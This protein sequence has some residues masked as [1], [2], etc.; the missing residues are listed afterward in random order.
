MALS[1]LSISCAVSAQTDDLKR[2]D[3]IIVTGLV[4]HKQADELVGN[5]TAMTRGEIVDNLTASLGETLSGQPGIASTAFGQGASRPILRGLGSD[6]VL[7]LTNGL[8]VIDAS[9]AS[10]DHQ[11]AVDGIDAQKIEILRGPA[12][13][14]YG[15][16]A[17]GGVVNVIDG[18]VAEEM[19]EDDFAADLYAALN[20]GSDGLEAAGRSQFTLGGNFAVT[21]SASIRELH[22]YDINGFSESAATRTPG[23]QE[24]EELFNTYVNTQTLSGGLS[25]IGDRAYLGL[26]LREQTSD[27]GLPAEDPFIDLEQ[28]RTDLKGGIE[29]SGMVFTGLTG[30]ISF[31]DYQHGETLPNGDVETVFK[32]KGNEARF[33]AAYGET[34][35]GGVIGLQRLDKEFEAI[36][37]E[38]FVTPTDTQS[39]GLFAFHHIELQNGVHLEGGLRYDDV[40]ILNRAGLGKRSFN[41]ISASF[42]LSKNLNENWFFGG[43][44][45]Y[46]TRAPS[47]VELFADGPHLATSQYEVGDIT[48]DEEHGLNVELTARYKSD[49]FSIGANVFNTQFSDFIFLEPGTTL[50]GGVPVT[51]KDGLD[52]FVFVQDEADFWGGEIYGEWFIGEGMKADWVLDG[53]FDFVKAERSNGD[54][55][56][57]MPPVTFNMGAKA[58]WDYV[59]LKGELTHAFEQDEQASFELPTDGYTSLDV[60]A[61]LDLAAL[62]LGQAGTKAFIEVHNLTDEEIR[63]STSVLKEEVPAPGRNVRMGVR[64]S[65]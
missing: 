52:V 3:L 43:A 15:G 20:T 35:N 31:V 21:L 54:N 34:D 36:G 65:F 32:N 11:V 24:V 12:A 56:P 40:E 28:T 60:K 13:L 39:L 55:L 17:I 49:S 23:A 5:V 25:W 51:V 45:S 46:T 2:E 8:G 41:P 7:V 4:D 42:S 1:A 63:H 10:P 27:Y 58:S 16:N 6:R 37:D 29:L 53:S 48:L 26:A 22:D 57:L 33:E 64:L 14:A 61:N 62:G 19:P 30:G 47:D 9:A 44:L 38:A 18:L 50:D 59:S